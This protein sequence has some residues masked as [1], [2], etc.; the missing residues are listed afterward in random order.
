[1]PAGELDAGSFVRWA[2]MAVAFV[3]YPIG[4][5]LS[6]FATASLVPR[7]IQKGA[8]DLL[9]SKPMTRTWIFVARYLGALLVGGGVLFYLVV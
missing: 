3:L 2:Q 7:M 9:L 8:I 4:V 6:L 1:M 5:L